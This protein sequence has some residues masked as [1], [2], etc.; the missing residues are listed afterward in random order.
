MT[1]RSLLHVPRTTR[2]GA[3]LARGTRAL[4]AAVAILALLVAQ[5]MLAAPVAGAPLTGGFS[6]KI[7]SGL[8]DLNG[9]NI[10][11]SADI[12]TVINHWGACAGCA[13]DLN[14]D[15]TVNT[16]EVI[17]VINAWGNCPG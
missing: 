2:G 1:M 12:L 9:D 6:P 7:I 16:Y 3:A 8:A 4:P 17:A 15:S 10:V 13:M 5:L 11:N 14:G